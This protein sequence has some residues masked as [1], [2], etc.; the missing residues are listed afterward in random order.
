MRHVTPAPVLPHRTMTIAERKAVVISEIA[1]GPM[2]SRIWFPLFGP[3]LARR[4]PKGG[5][6]GG[7]SREVW[8]DLGASHEKSVDAV[9][10][11]W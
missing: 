11:S 8:K 3:V 5:H 6:Q 10:L 9:L 2:A 1:E 7:R 4:A